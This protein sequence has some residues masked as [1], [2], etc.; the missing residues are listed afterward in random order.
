[1]KK[2]VIPIFLILIIILSA[3]CNT[4]N[5]LEYVSQI[6]STIDAF[7]KHTL[8]IGFDINVNAATR[9]RLVSAGE[10]II[11]INKNYEV[12][13]S[14]PDGSGAERLYSGSSYINA[15][16][17]YES[18]L[19]FISVQK[20]LVRVSGDE[21]TIIAT[22]E[23]GNFCI[24]GGK[25]FYN[26][27]DTEENTNNLHICNPDGSGGQIVTTLDK[28]RIINN[29]HESPGDIV[30]TKDGNIC[31]S[32]RE[33]TG[34]KYYSYDWTTEEL[35]DIE[36]NSYIPLWK[37]ENEIILK[38]MSISSTPVSGSNDYTLTITD[39]RS[40]KQLAETKV[41]GDTIY[42]CGNDLYVFDAYNN[43]E[44]FVLE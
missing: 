9:G 12:I 24:A 23:I 29:I 15:L 16:E 11:Y 7:E 35:K 43:I 31:F 8:N 6:P 19:F 5:G 20:G 40:G 18:T 44:Y 1:M 26:L 34:Y 38:N 21:T 37:N 42:L 10:D 25:L 39:I 22:G 17:V 30:G 14:K 2:F 32:V 36:E 13:R 41:H 4:Q 27:I 3:S 33:D 28:R